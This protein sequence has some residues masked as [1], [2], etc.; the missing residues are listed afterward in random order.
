MGIYLILNR[1]CGIKFN[2]DWILNHSNLDLKFNPLKIYQK[3]KN[4]NF[5]VCVTHTH[6]IKLKFYS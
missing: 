1:I 3:S 6:T 4:Q 2:F 5:I